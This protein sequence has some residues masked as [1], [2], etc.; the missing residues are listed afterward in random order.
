MEK[1]KIK[2]GKCASGPC[3]GNVV[4]EVWTTREYDPST[5]P[6]IFGPKSEDQYKEL[7]HTSG[8]F[9]DRCGIKYQFVPNEFLSRS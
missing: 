2:R 7:N 8:L 4:E 5:G 6:L 1:R 9:C 3:G